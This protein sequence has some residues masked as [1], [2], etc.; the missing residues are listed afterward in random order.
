MGRREFLWHRTLQYL[1]DDA[2]A[3]VA[4]DTET[5][6]LGFYDTPFCATLS[7]RS[8]GG[9]LHSA[10]VSLEGDER[11]LG[12]QELREALATVDVWVFH[13]AKFDLQKLRLIGALPDAWQSWVVM[14]DTQV[15]AALT[16][17]NERKKLKHLAR[18]VLGEETDEEEVLKVVRRK[19][20]LTKDDGFFHIPREV[21]VPYAIKDTEF[22]LRLFEKMK[23]QLP[24]DVLGAYDRE[25]DATLVLLD[26][27][28]NGIA[29]DLDYL[30]R[31]TSEYG[32][33]VMEGWGRLTELT[34]ITDPKMPNSPK[35]LTEAF[36]ARGIH[37]DST[38]EPELAKLG[39]DELA[40]T[41]LQ[42]RSDKK[43]HKTYLKA[44][45]DEQRDG[46][47]HPWFNVIQA[48]TGRMSS[49][50]ASQ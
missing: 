1:A 28:A 44:L 18:V 3:C 43:M 41:L 46:V 45:L 31:T 23:P 13:N 20:K 47:V 14:E 49:S 34:G 10:Y 42:Y 16:N 8:Q 37:L 11:E 25:I 48:R 12:I 21:L 27:E 6:G 33:K 29:L 38:A 39:D 35:Q 9:S 4:V 30:R 24:E 7:W 26:M 32:V 5:T 15:I 40:T 50:S 36:A 22:T 17:E 2:P 19:L